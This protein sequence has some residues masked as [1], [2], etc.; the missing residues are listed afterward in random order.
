[1]V[2]LEIERKNWIMVKRVPTGSRQLKEV[3]ICQT[4][5]MPVSILIVELKALEKADGKGGPSPF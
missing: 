4:H 2:F 5:N 3:I 1:M